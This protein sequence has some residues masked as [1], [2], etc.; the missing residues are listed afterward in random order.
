MT[1]APPPVAPKKSGKKA[2][3]AAIKRREEESESY[4]S[5]EA[6]LS[7]Y[8]SPAIRAAEQEAE[9]A[10]AAMSAGD[11]SVPT[12]E[13]EGQTPEVKFNALQKLSSC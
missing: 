3:N 7:A 11:L 9:E 6:D 1:P 12:P 2:L 13:T 4:S 10:A 8:K 5:R